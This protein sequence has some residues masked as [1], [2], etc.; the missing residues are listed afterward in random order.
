MSSELDI[1]IVANG[2]AAP[3]LSRL[4]SSIERQHCSGV[5][6]RVVT[7][8][9]TDTTIE[10]LRAFPWA[11]RLDFGAN[12]GYGGAVNRAILEGDHSALWLIAC[13]CDLEFPAGSLQAMKHALGAAACDV[14]C[15]APMLLDPP[16]RGGG[17]QP[18]VGEFPS[19]AGLLLGRLRPRRTRKYRPAPAT[20]GDVPWATGACLALRRSAF[21]EVGGFDDDMFLDY[22][23]TDL[24]KRLADQGWRTRF[25]P[26]W[27]VMHRSPN[28]Q[29]PPDPA[30]QVHTRQSLV[31]YLARHRPRWEVF[32]L[33][34]LLR[35]TLAV[36]RSS[37]PFAP[38]W[39]AAL[40]TQRQLRGRP[41]S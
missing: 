37:H 9:C 38:S 23:D 31:R 29:R 39:R 14:G 15:I 34:L 26:S 36:H 10:C 28:A 5:D 21:A 33:G 6:V 25:E 12:I 13:N 1:I 40:D 2:S 11:P 27:K 32:V 8:N 3:D 20:A 35:S 22:E 30:R 18:S 7:N 17:I 41:A 4:L 16:E 19:L 24:C